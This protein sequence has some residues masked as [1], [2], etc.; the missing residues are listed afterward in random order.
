MKV[1]WK[2]WVI[3]WKRQNIAQNL[4]WLDTP[5]SEIGI[6]IQN[7]LDELVRERSWAALSDQEQEFYDSMFP[8]N[9]KS[10]N[11]NESVMR[12]FKSALTS[13]NEW[14]V[15]LQVRNRLWDDLYNEIFLDSDNPTLMESTK[16]KDI[17]RIDSTLALREGWYFDDWI[18]VDDLV[19]ESTWSV[20]TWFWW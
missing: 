15:D 8:S 10:Q 7:T 4:Q 13:S 19:K 1:G 3:T 18:Y 9:E 6:Q 20:M 14:L 2:S 12:W 17:E 16:Q 5:W 11:L